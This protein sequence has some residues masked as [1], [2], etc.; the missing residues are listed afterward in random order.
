MRAHLTAVGAVS[1]AV[2]CA[3]CASGQP[4]APTLGRR[5]P[6]STNA[7]EWIALHPSISPIARDSA[8]F[9]YD[10]ATSTIVMSGGESGCVGGQVTDF[11]DT[12]TWSGDSWMLQHPA[13]TGPIAID[14]PAGY[15]PTTK[16]VVVLIGEP[17]AMSTFHDDWDGSNWS[18]PLDNRGCDAAGNNCQTEIFPGLQG[19]IADDLQSGQFLLW[20]SQP[21]NDFSSESPPPP[22]ASTWTFN[23]TSWTL[24][25]PLSQPTPAVGPELMVYDAALGEVVLYGEYTRQMWTWNGSTWTELPADP[26]APPAR[27]DSSMVF[28]AKLGKLVLFGGADVTGYDLGSG[29]A[30]YTDATPL[31][32]TWTWDGT[33][34]MR[35]SL[36]ISPTPRYHAQM[37]YDQRNGTIVLFGGSLDSGTDSND[38]WE[39]R[40]TR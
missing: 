5:S 21:A 40:S 28:D 13:T 16:K 9:V 32:D 34:W 33:S 18:G 36:P 11:Q 37:A 24:L 35:L 4:P 17:C 26:G 15:D 20:S 10:G 29:G 2:L 27:A 1:L 7:Y 8:L 22:G 39:F 31:N 12:W 25:H 14:A 6:A 38:T 23:G 3:G 19:A 30:T